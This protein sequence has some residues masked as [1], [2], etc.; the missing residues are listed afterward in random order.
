MAGTI[1]SILVVVLLALYVIGIFVYDY[2]RRKKGAP[3]IFVDACESE[4]H[5]K[6]LVKAFR[7]A[8]PKQK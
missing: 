2:K 5:G 7:K 3:S 4:G 1:V 6:R 8:Y